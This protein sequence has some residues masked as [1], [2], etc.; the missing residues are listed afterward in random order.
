MYRCTD[1]CFDCF[2]FALTANQIGDEG[3]RALAEAL[4]TIKTLVFINLRGKNFGVV[5]C[6]IGVVLLTGNQIGV[7]GA[8]ALAEALK[9]NKTLGII[10]IGGKKC[11]DVRM[12]ALIVSCLR[13]QTIKLVLRVPEH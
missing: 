8:R 3:A 2:L 5:V 9:T 1:V 6:L 12:F 10:D 7:E 11:I 13:L 4:K